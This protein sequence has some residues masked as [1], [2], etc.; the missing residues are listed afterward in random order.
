MQHLEIARDIAERMNRLYGGNKW[1]K[2]GGRG[3]KI[4][5]L[6]EPFIPPA[7]ARVMSLTV[8]CLLW[9]CLTCRL[10]E[11]H[12]EVSSHGQSS[13]RYGRLSAML[14]LAVARCASGCIT[15]SP[16]K[17]RCSVQDG[18]S[19]MSKSAES[20]MSRINLLDDP[21]TIQ[22]KLKRCKTDSYE[23]LEFGNPERPEA[24]NLVTIYSL[25][26]GVTMVSCPCLTEA[27]ADD[28]SG[29][30]AGCY[31]CHGQ[32]CCV[33]GSSSVQGSAP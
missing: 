1:K 5:K 26:T 11:T 14:A 31:A 24:T 15:G 9:P 18:T 32:I 29:S 25:C 20:D 2:L 28:M 19:K 10:H 12:R 17:Q 23:G 6:P 3:G 30:A 4:F 8:S 16:A 21:T 33:L 22:D 7:G 13:L 27:V